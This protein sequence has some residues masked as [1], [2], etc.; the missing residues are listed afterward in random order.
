MGPDG[1]ASGDEGGA[2]DGSGH[3]DACIVSNQNRR[4]VNEVVRTFM[5]CILNF[6]GDHVCVDHFLVLGVRI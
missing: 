3:E 2:R 6:Y 5:I 1:A 4:S